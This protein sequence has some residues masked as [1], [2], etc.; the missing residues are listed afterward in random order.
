[1]AVAVTQALPQPPQNSRRVRDFLIALQSALDN[2]SVSMKTGLE[3]TWDRFRESK[4]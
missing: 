2:G 3:M 1:M 4:C